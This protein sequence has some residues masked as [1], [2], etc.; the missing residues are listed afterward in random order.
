MYERSGKP[1][2]GLGQAAEAGQRAG[3]SD[4][5]P[6]QTWFRWAWTGARLRLGHEQAAALDLDDGAG[7]RADGGAGPDGPS[8]VPGAGSRGR[9]VDRDTVTVDLTWVPQNE[10]EDRDLNRRGVRRQSGVG[11]LPGGTDPGSGRSSGGAALSVRQRLR[12]GSPTSAFGPHDPADRYRNPARV[13]GTGRMPDARILAKGNRD[14][15]DIDLDPHGV[16]RFWPPPPPPSRSPWLRRPWHRTVAPFDPPLPAGPRLTPED[17]AEGAGAAAAAEAQ[18]ATSRRRGRS[19]SRCWS[20][21]PLAPAGASAGSGAAGDPAASAAVLDAVAPAAR[22]DP[23]TC[24]WPADRL[25]RP[26]PQPHRGGVPRCAP[27]RSARSAA[28]RTDP[29]PIGTAGRAA[30]DPLGFP[31]AG[32]PRV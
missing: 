9:T 10:E 7:D 28:R 12:P 19:S 5:R 14:H 21:L 6:R 18:A 22:S 3:L 17:I 26:R 4:G 23:P 25:P 2:G 8:P 16:A 13:F 31:G 15:D 1:V 24:P 20:G 32:P 29:Q 27:C 11:R 30:Y